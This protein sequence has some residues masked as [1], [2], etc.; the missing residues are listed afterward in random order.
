MMS[1]GQ[2]PLPIQ[3]PSFYH[4][5]NNLQ[6]VQSHQLQS[7]LQQLQQ[8][9]FVNQ[10]QPLKEESSAKALKAKPRINMT[11]EPLSKEQQ[12]AEQQMQNQACN[13]KVEDSKQ[14][15]L[16]LNPIQMLRPDEQNGLLS[17]GLAGA[18]MNQNLNIVNLNP[19]ANLLQQMKKPSNHNNNHAYFL[20]DKVNGM[21]PDF[22]NLDDYLLKYQNKDDGVQSN[23]GQ[24]QGG[25]G[26]EPRVNRRKHSN[27]SANSKGSK[28][29]LSRNRSHGSMDSRGSRR[30]QRMDSRYSFDDE[31]FLEFPLERSNT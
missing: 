25:S 30:K 11:A 28:R 27:N 22:L 3:S 6:L 26:A 5:P 31:E 14:G 20:N 24:N 21:T 8:Q 9:Q 7:P 29:G 13:L 10:Q 18:N 23:S 12:L 4:S 19:K 15:Q 17:L 2:Q 16:Q 1:Q